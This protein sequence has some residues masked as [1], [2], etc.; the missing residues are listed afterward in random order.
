MTI[1]T[2]IYKLVIQW[3]KEADQYQKMIEEARLKNLPHDQMLSIMT[4][5]R[6]CSRELEKALKPKYD[7]DEVR[8]SLIS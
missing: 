6:G 2:E 8:E 5:L 3:R 4:A 7:F 1:P